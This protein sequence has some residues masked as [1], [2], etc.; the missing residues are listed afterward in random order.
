MT[1]LFYLILGILTL[2]CLYRIGKREFTKR[3]NQKHNRHERQK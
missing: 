2:V 1:S 3:E